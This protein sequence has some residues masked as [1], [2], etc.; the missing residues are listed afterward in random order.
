MKIIYICIKNSRENIA[1]FSISFK[2]ISPS[3]NRNRGRLALQFALRE[4]NQ[5]VS[6]SFRFKKMKTSLTL[7]EY[8]VE[9][10]IAQA[11]RRCMIWCL[12]TYFENDPSA[13]P[14]AR[15]FLNN[16]FIILSPH[17]SSSLHP[18]ANHFCSMTSFFHTPFP[19]D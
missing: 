9:Q 3:I 10:V 14:L 15:E 1:K 19:N 11:F 8:I 17:S 7:A 16:V 13:H 5:P 4:M 2:H 18:F 12:Y 6:E